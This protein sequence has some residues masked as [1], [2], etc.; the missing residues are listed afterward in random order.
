MSN[1]LLEVITHFYSKLGSTMDTVDEVCRSEC[2]MS[3]H[4]K[5]TSTRNNTAVL[6]GILDGPQ[7]ISNSI[8][9]LSDCVL[10]GTL[11]VSKSEGGKGRER[12]GERKRGIGEE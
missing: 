3:C 2:S 4:F 9:D 6:N 1:Q 10:V 7:T 11:R 12:G 5:C 8:L